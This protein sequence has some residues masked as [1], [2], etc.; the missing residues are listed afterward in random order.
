MICRFVH[1][2]R[3]VAGMKLAGISLQLRRILRWLGLVVESGEPIELLRR[4]RQQG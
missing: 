3:F 4:K 2:N 1:Q